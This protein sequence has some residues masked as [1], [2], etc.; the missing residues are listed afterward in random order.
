MS[1]GITNCA[2]VLVI[3]CSLRYRREIAL[4]LDKLSNGEEIPEESRVAQKIKEGKMNG[5]AAL[6]ALVSAWATMEH[7]TTS[8]LL[9]TTATHSGRSPGSYRH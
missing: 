2:D 4:Y 3:R 5:H 7:E 9:E 1:V 8:V 6:M